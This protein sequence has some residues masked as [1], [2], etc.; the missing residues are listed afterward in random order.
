[1]TDHTQSRAGVDGTRPTTGGARALL[2]GQWIDADRL[3]VPVTDAGF[4]LGATV[5]EQLRTFGGELFR[6]DAHLERLGRSLSIVGVDPG[7]SRDE[8]ADQARQLVA[9]NHA[10]LADGDDL[11]LS[12][13]VTPGPYATFAPPGE[14][15]VALHTY[16]LPFRLWA[17]KYDVGQALRTVSIRQVPDECWPAELKCRSRMHYFLADR[18]A[19]AAEPGARAVLLDLAGHVTES[20]TANV[21]VVGSDG[22]LISP[23]RSAILPGISLDTVLDTARQLGLDTSQSPIAPDDLYKA[24]EVLLTSTS[25]CI[26]PVTT[27]DGATIGDG[28]PG[29]VFHR[30][31]DA[32]S[33]RVGVDI[34]QQATRIAAGCRAC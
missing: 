2:N 32:W 33:R 13:F 20:S 6:L 19:A 31:M 10:L 4:M 25:S 12:I 16:H 21:I 14:P 26:L 11:G 28:S 15:I 22:R 9:N 18:E 30:L 24:S 34:T 1:M 29:P 3:T 5:A 7:F 8:L 17:R 27:I 23:P